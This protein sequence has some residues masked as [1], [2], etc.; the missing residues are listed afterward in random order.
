MNETSGTATLP[1]TNELGYS[2]YGGITSI[3]DKLAYDSGTQ[4]IFHIG[5]MSNDIII[6]MAINPQ[7][8]SLQ[9]GVYFL[10]TLTSIE[11]IG[12]TISDRVYLM[13]QDSSQNYIF[14]YDTGT[15]TFSST[16]DNITRFKGA[17]IAMLESFFLSGGINTNNNCAIFK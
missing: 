5:Y 17:F 12:I 13:A 3:Q 14:P 9:H 7:T 2:G 11:T 16:Y 10:N 1:W 15:N 6:F 8:G 4:E